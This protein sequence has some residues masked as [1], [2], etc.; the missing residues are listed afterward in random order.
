MKYL[1]DIIYYAEKFKQQCDGDSNI[2][3]YSAKTTVN[4]DNLENIKDWEIQFEI[5]VSHLIVNNQYYGYIHKINGWLTTLKNGKKHYVIRLETNNK[6]IQNNIDDYAWVF[7]S[8]A[9]CDTNDHEE[10]IFE[11]NKAYHLLFECVEEQIEFH[12]EE[13]RQAE[14]D[15]EYEEYRKIQAR[16]GY[17][18][19]MNPAAI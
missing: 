16:R 13:H 12:Y 10:F 19:Y 18:P 1:N 7:G 15:E 11:L 6:N 14:R 2:E 9:I 3:S 4:Y 17:V 8:A 5:G